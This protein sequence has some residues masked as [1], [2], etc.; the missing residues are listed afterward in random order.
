MNTINLNEFRELIKKT[1]ALEVDG[2]I[3]Q[4]YCIF[5][6]PE[7]EFFLW[8]SLE[9][10]LFIKFYSDDNQ[11]IRHDEKGLYLMDELGIIFAVMPIMKEIL[12]D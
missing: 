11:E 5:D 3:V 4:S 9:N 12:N 10:N 8:I 6:N 7:N 1:Y 2:L